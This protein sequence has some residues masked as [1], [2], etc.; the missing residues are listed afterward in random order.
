[1]KTQKYEELV[2]DYRRA[3][4]SQLNLVDPAKDLRDRVG[5]RIRVTGHPLIP[6]AMT[7]KLWWTRMTELADG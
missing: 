7:S 1:M 3:P 4:L 5:A 2:R 6:V